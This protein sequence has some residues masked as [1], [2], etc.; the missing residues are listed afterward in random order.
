MYEIQNVQHIISQ[1]SGK[2][3]NILIDMKIPCTN[4]S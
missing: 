2:L 4:L 3:H 1:F